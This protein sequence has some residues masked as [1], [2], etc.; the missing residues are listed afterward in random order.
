[1]N[2]NVFPTDDALT[3][4]GDTVRVPEPSA[5][6]TLT[7]G[8]LARPVSVPLGVEISC[9]ANVAV[10]MVAAA[11]A[12]GPPEAFEPYVIVHV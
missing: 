12:P 5:A 8:A 4:L 10:A 7:L 11:T 3:A 1:V 2:V 6:T 9:V